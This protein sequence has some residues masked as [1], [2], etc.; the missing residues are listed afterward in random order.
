MKNFDRENSFYRNFEIVLSWAGFASKKIILSAAGEIRREYEAQLQ[1]A[2]EEMRR[3]RESVRL[4][5]ETLVRKIREK[6]EREKLSQLAGDKLLAK[7]LAKGQLLNKNKGT[8]KI[9]ETKNG[10]NFDWSV[11]ESEKRNLGINWS[12]E[13]VEK[14]CQSLA[15]KL[16][17]GD[18][19]NQA[20]S[21]CSNLLEEPG[22]SGTQ[23]FGSR[24]KE[25]LRVPIDILSSK[26]KHL[27]VQVC[28][29]RN[30]NDE[31]IGSAESAASHDSINQEI[32]HFKPIK[33]TPR[34]CLKISAGRQIGK[35]LLTFAPTFVSFRAV[36]WIF[37]FHS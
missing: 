12:L 19:K 26:K 3:E 8:T 13:R 1:I 35:H 9:Y 28:L 14:H 23:I 5:D 27:D 30:D 7:A 11:E 4:A 17:T 18:A 24:V 32:H 21:E 22:C 16:V 15:P 36:T 33:P 29:N 6:E 10:E 20:R 34:T 31:R 2:E 25:E 37:C